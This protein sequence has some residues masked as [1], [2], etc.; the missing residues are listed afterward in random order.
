MQGEA[1]VRGVVCCHQE[2][3]A[4]R[5]AAG[6]AG[7]GR[8]HGAPPRG[9]GGRAGRRGGPA[10]EGRGARRRRE[11]RRRHAVRPPRRGVDHQLVHD[12]EAGGDAGGVRGAARV[13][14]EAGPAGA[15][16]RP[17]R[18]AGGGEDV[19]QPGGGG[20][21]HRGLGVRGRVQ[22]ARRVRQRRHGQGSPGG[23][24]AGLRHLP[25]PGHVRR[26]DVGGRRDPARLRQ[27]VALRRRLVHELRVGAAVHVGVAHDTDAGLLR[28]PGDHEC[29]Q[30][31]RVDGDRDVHLRAANVRDD[32]DYACKEL[33]HDLEV[34]SKTAHQ[35][36]QRKECDHQAAVSSR[37]RFRTA[38]LS[39]YSYN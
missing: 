4:A 21:A 13:D 36:R 31:V 26:G 5:S 17:R 24:V 11:R 27:D 34:Y 9:G 30:S 2:P 1:G 15:M 12:G 8:E 6:R 18:R 39:V 33:E 38:L 23:Q 35:P 20:G 29:C 37:W 25:V 19:G 32:V 3:Q 22:R 14:A 16:E 7:R 28:G 10:A